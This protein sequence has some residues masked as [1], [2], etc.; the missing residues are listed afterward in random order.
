MDKK[1]SRIRGGTAYRQHQSFKKHIRERDKYTCQICGEWG[2][3]VDHIIPYAISHETRPDG[4]RVLCMKC[5]LAIR[6][7]RKDASLPLEEWAEN[8]KAELARLESS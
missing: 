6:R 7:V 2:K 4:V 8:I 5:N 3:I 1:N